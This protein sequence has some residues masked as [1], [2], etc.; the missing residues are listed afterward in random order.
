MAQLSSGVRTAVIQRST[1][2]IKNRWLPLWFLLPSMLILAVMQVYPSL[3]SLYLS[4]TRVRGGE[5][6]EVG[7]ANFERLLN[8]PTFR[9]SLRNTF[10]YTA[11]YLILTVGLGLLV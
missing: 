8:S 10:I 7:L 4:T 5:L 6:S 2:T 11:S 3:Y 1:P 9:E